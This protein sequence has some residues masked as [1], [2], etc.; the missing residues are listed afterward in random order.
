LQTKLGGKQQTKPKL[1]ASVFA[2]EVSDKKIVTYRK[3]DTQ[4]EKYAIVN[5]SLS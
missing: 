5:Q 1:H 2:V 3:Y 4:N